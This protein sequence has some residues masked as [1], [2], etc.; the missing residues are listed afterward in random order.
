M[1]G[2]REAFVS[3]IDAFSKALNR[4]RESGGLVSRTIG[5]SSDDPSRLLR[6][7]LA[8]V[9]FA[10]L[11]EFI[12]ARSMEI[13]ATISSAEIPFRELPKA[14][15][16][17]STVNVIKA[18]SKRLKWRDD[19]EKIRHAQKHA[20]MVAST[21]TDDYELSYLAFGF[22]S[23]NLKSGRVLQIMKTIGVNNGWDNINKVAKRVSLS[24]PSLRDVYDQAES[25]RHKSAHQADA[26]TEAKKLGDFPNHA[27]AISIGFDALVSEAARLYQSADSDFLDDEHAKI[28]DASDLSIR[29]MDLDQEDIWR[30]AHEDNQRATRTGEYDVV[31]ESS[32]DHIANRGEVLVIRNEKKIPVDWRIGGLD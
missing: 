14:L 29:F 19:I 4:A 2:A 30:E 7:G 1:S 11:E 3:R 16:Q 31:L 17:D 25:R 9:G 28:I 10:T 23:S 15:R 22:E 6:N 32:L 18:L 27:M 24:S 21:A 8:V 5:D 26:D 12:Q 20:R 13:L